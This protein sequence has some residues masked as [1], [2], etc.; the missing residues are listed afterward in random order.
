MANLALRE[1]LS[2]SKLAAWMDENDA[3]HPLCTIVAV[4]LLYG[5]SNDQQLDAFA[6]YI[7]LSRSATGPAPLS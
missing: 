4:M 2:T 3:D 7:E 5:Y 1:G 6:A